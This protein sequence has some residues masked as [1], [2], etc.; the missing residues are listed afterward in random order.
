MKTFRIYQIDA[1][2]TVH[3]FL[4]RVDA[5]S[6]RTDLKNVYIIRSDSSGVSRN[7]P[8]FPYLDDR[9]NGKTSLQLQDGD[10]VMVPR[11]AEDVYVLGAVQYPGPHPYIPDL[12]VRDYIG[13]AGSMN[14][15]TPPK[16]AK[17]IP[18]VMP[19]QRS[20]R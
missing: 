5:F 7:I 8:V 1:G 6:R 14:Q 18:P 4:L 16:K 3:E 10:V 15:A 9:S 11:R 13:L 17:L 20:L 19:S 2:E 12:K